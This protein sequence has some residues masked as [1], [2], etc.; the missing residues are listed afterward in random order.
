MGDEFWSGVAGAGLGFLVSSAGTW[1]V[2]R[3]VEYWQILD[4][5]SQRNAHRRPMPTL[6][7]LGVILGFWAGLLLLVFS[8]FPIFIENILWAQL[9]ATLVLLLLVCDDGGRP[10]G[11]L[12]KF[13]LQVGATSVWLY[14]GGNLE[15]VT[16]PLVGQLDLGGWGWAI[17]GLWCVGMCNAYNFMDGIDGITAIETIVVGC[18]ALL[19]FVQLDTPLWGVALLLVAVS[20]GFLAFNFPPAQI[21][22][23][24]VGAVFL[25]FTMAILGV[26]GEQAGLPIWLYLV[27]LGYYLFDISYTLLRRALNGENLLQAHRKHLYQRLN[28]LGWSHLKINFWICFLTL[29][30]GLGGWAFHFVDEIPGVALVFLGGCLLLGTTVWIEVKD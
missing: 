16:L 9:G 26:L 21:F 25:G 10:L 12:E 24:D 2:L 4:R 22:A 19:S 6:G 5:P 29:T 23:G 7:G 27:F 8:K 13:A 14:W 28:K 20:G 15:W 3:A 11:V 17:T 30:L 18:L 1:G